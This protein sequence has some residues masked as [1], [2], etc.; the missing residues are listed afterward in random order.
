MT[1]IF[2]IIINLIKIYLIWYK[3]QWS[4]NS[5]FIIIKVRSKSILGQNWQSSNKN[6]SKSKYTWWQH[7]HTT[8]QTP[9]LDRASNYAQWQFT[10]QEHILNQY[11]W[12]DPHRVSCIAVIINCPTMTSTAG[13][14]PCSGHSIWKT[15]WFKLDT[16]PTIPTQL[17]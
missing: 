4:N 7:Y 12:H 16:A 15:A 3:F 8:N 5:K 13:S 11:W 9:T 2:E 1:K 17:R 6:I 14:T 10:T